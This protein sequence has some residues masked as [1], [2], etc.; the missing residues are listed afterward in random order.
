M[1]STAHSTSA[2][3]A[4]EHVLSGKPCA[5]YINYQVLQ[6]KGEVIGLGS[7][8]HLTSFSIGVVPLWNNLPANIASSPPTSSLKFRLKLLPI[9]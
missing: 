5:Y 3:D 9:L 4:M 7:T 6:C 2:A 8:S 1:S